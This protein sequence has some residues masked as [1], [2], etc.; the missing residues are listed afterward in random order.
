MLLKGRTALITGGNAGIGAAITQKFLEN[1]AHVVF[2]YK[3]D[4]QQAAD[5]VAQARRD[6]QTLEALQVDLTDRAATLNTVNQA[7]GLLNGQVDIL[8]NNAGHLLKRQSLADMTEDFFDAVMDVNLKSAFRVTQAALPCIKQGG[9]IVNMSSLAAFDGGGAGA[10][11]YAA[12]KAALL[13]LSRGMAKEF[14][15]RGIRVNAVA[16]GFIANTAF[17][18]TFTPPEAQQATIGKIPLGRGGTPDDVAGAVLYLASDLSSFLTGE[19]I[20]INGGMAFL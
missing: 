9:S 7:V 5:F 17:H 11:V 4:P 2:T 20:Q 6:G 14:S 10:A 13:A 1:G 8:V 12:S 18:N 16:P 19:V 15:P 3:T